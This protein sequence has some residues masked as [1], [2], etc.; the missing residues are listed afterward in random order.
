MTYNTLGQK[1]ADQRHIEAMLPRGPLDRP[2]FLSSSTKALF[3]A[4]EYLTNMVILWRILAVE[5]SYTRIKEI[6]PTVRSGL[7]GHFPVALLL[8]EQDSTIESSLSQ[9]VFFGNWGLASHSGHCLC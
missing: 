7:K 1:Y 3:Y 5:P 2:L 9:H 6:E 8:L 4:M